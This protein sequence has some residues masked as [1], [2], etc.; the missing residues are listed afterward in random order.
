MR[1]QISYLLRLW[2]DGKGEASWRAS[3]EDIRTKETLTF[4]SLEELAHY[5]KQETQKKHVQDNT[6]TLS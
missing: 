5:L 2:N 3:L 1:K 6:F 4:A